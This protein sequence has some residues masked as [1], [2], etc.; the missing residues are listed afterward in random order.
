M[1]RGQTPPATISVEAAQSAKEYKGQI[2][3][4][5]ATA[6]RP[7]ISI[8]DIGLIMEDAFLFDEQLSVDKKAQ[9]I[10]LETELLLHIV[11]SAVHDTAI[12]RYNDSS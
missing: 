2:Q 10:L 6:L 5:A 8:V 12:K 7:Q 4:G 1:A 3:I 11:Q 9:P